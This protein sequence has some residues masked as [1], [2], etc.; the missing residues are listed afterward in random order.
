MK[1]RSTILPLI[2]LALLLFSA[3]PSGY[4]LEKQETISSQTYF[5]AY[6]VK[7]A[8]CVPLI[9]SASDIPALTGWGN[10]KWKI[11]NASD[12]AQ[13]YFNQ[14]IN[15][16]YGFHSIE[17]IASFTKATHLDP[18]CA[19][20]WYGKALAEGPTINYPN[21]YRPPSDALEAAIKS[22]ELSTNCTA[23]EK[24]LINAIQ[25]RYSSDTTIAVIDLRKKYADAMQAVYEKHNTNADVI[26]LYADALLLLHP[27]DLYAHDFTPKPWTPKIRTL[28][29]HAIA[30]SPK[31]PGANHYYIH[32][33]EASATPQLALKS[34]HM[35]DTLM[36]GVSHVTHMP[37]HIYI[38][39]GY[40]K[41]GIKNND[42]AVAGYDNYLKQYA[43]VQNNAPLYAL[44]NMHMGI[45]CAQM[46]GNYKKAISGAIELQNAIPSDYLALKSADGN[47][48]QYLYMQPILTNL[49]FGK[50]D[51]ILKS[52][53]ADSL[54]YCGVLQ[55]FAKGIA[56]SRKGDVASA[57]QELRLLEKQIQDKVLDSA[58]DNFSPFR[59]PA[60]VAKLILEGVIAEEQKQYG[61]AI[62]Y[63]QQA[64]KA[65]DHI[66][67]DEPRDWAIP[68]RQYLANVLV[69]AGKYEEA[70]AVLKH[71]LVINPKNGW[72]LT[73]LKAAY[74]RTGN[75]KALA[76]VNAQLKDA[77]SIKD[78]E[79]SNV[80]F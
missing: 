80:V 23:V 33:M 30:L 60:T 37:S 39:T 19:M 64:V 20:A 1:L 25:Q 42:R 2:L 65:E 49:R 53:V 36:P 21:G 32:T 67:Y 69:K 28:L 13:F 58:L 77:F 31:N 54:T 12:S 75:V 71:D 48:I 47:Y 79:I 14:G 41:Q 4:H 18:N 55:H 51:N 35:L 7:A 24:D 62:N 26:T 56:Y 27:W 5:K 78:T 45:N 38:R 72:S 44:H 68:A 29:E 73:G 74:T 9:D 46:A 50:W 8:L 61:L 76:G 59:E 66:I 52:Q 17:A 43:A 63:L 11:S 34:A 22:K 57:Q 15:M 10:Y 70:T 6:T 16:Y 3:Q 40:Y